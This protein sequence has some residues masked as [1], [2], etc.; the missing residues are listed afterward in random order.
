MQRGG[1]S[2]SR[3]LEVSNAIATVYGPME[4][5]KDL[6]GAEYFRPPQ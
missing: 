2:N 1:D 3:I 4:M 6:Y 5:I